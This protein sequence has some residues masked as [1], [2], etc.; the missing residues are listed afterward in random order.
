[1]DTALNL[2]L[3]SVY[4]ALRAIPAE[5]ATLPPKIEIGLS[6]GVFSTYIL[7]TCTCKLFTG[8]PTFIGT[9]LLQS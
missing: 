2:A 1:M 7:Y 3:T 5:T 9:T 6:T 4:E 8:I